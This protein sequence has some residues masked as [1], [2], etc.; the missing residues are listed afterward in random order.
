ML[1]LSRATYLE[2]VL[3]AKLNSK[4]RTEISSFIEMTAQSSEMA[5]R[6]KVDELVTFLNEHLSTRMFLVGSNITAADVVVLLRVAAWFRALKDYQK[7]E[8]PHV[9]R[10]IDHLQH[11]PGL[12][13]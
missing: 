5:D 8:M 11:L 2:D 9:F 12:S 1:E 3:F 6:L 13:E 7:L 10:W 4:E